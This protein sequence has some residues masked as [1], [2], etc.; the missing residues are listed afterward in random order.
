MAGESF[1]QRVRAKLTEA[2]KKAL[3][4]AA[5]EERS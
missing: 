1:K 3:S 2:Q 5:W 4:R